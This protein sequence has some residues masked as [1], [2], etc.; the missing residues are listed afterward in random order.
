MKSNK[1]LVFAAI[2]LLIINAVLVCM[3]WNEK[4]KHRGGAGRS[5]NR[6]EWFADQLKLDSNQKKEHKK[7]ISAH[8]ESMKPLF[9]SM[10]SL[11]NSL[12]VAINESATND[13]L[14]SNYVNKIADLN[15]EITLKTYT[16]FGS[17][18]K[19]LNEEQQKKYDEMVK[20]LMTRRGGPPGPSAGKR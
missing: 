2:A 9:D 8:F 12:Y 6:G 17:V 3:L 10:N 14:V 1:L 5:G 15:K 13:S 4:K 16:H 20:N 19:M 18:R 7:M 11:K